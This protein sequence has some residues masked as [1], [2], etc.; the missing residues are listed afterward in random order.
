[1]LSCR[2]LQ[3]LY[4]IPDGI[5]S[6]R[7]TAI[8]FRPSVS[9]PVKPGETESDRDNYRWCAEMAWHYEELLA[10][11][12]DL[13]AGV[14]RLRLH[15]KR[16]PL[17]DRLNDLS[18]DLRSAKQACVDTEH[19]DSGVKQTQKLLQKIDTDLATLG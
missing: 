6:E 10:D 7:F 15:Q 19:I 4:R 14:T 17:I 9:A 13:G 18:R 2:F 16:R 1:M 8:G 12:I 11:V 3:R 5:A